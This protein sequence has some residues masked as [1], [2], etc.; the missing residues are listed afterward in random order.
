LQTPRPNIGIDANTFGDTSQAYFGLIWTAVL[1]RDVFAPHDHI[2]ADCGFGPVF[3]NGD[4]AAR[5]SH[6]RLD[7]RSIRAWVWPAGSLHGAMY[8]SI[9]SPAGVAF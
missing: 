2:D 5:D 9:S 1:W 8:R 7:R 4:T 6:A 3:N